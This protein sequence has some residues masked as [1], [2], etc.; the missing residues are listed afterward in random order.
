[1]EQVAIEGAVRTAITVESKGDHLCVF[2]PPVERLEDYLDLIATVERMAEDTG[3][4][5][6]IEAI[7]AL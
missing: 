6:R 1:V 5:V 4:P 2:L 3:L 7:P